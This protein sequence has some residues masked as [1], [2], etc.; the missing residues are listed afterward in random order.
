MKIGKLLALP[1]LLLLFVPAVVL[2][3][4]NMAPPTVVLRVN[5]IDSLIE[6]VKFLVGLA[7]QKDAARQIEGLIKTKIGDK[8]LEGVDS[9]RP[10]GLYG[11]VGKDIQDVTAAVLLPIAD[12]KAFLNLL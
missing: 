8:G 11:R 6:H 12:E 10:F 1:L 9:R 2:G 3:Q 7:G 5:S 4:A